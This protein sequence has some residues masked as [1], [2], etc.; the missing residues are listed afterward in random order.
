M[1]NNQ[2]YTVHKSSVGNEIEFF[3]FPTG[4]V[5]IFESEPTGKIYLVASSLLDESQFAIQGLNDLRSDTSLVKALQGLSL[6][7]FQFLFYS[8]EAE[9]KSWSKGSRGTYV[10]DNHGPLVYAG[11]VGV[12]TLLDKIR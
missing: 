1:Y 5:L 2:Y 4:A 10:L 9:E 8:C 11:I 6:L 12:V 3:N 7:D